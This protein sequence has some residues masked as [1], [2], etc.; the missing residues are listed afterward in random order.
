MLRPTLLAVSL[1]LFG[2]MNAAGVGQPAT[3]RSRIG[4][5]AISPDGNLVAMDLQ[6][7]STS[8]IYTVS[9]VTGEA[10]R[11][12]KA[13]NGRET[14]PA[15]SPDGKKIAYTYWPGSGARSRIM[16]INVDGSDR[17][18]WPPSDVA[19]V[20]PV[21][22]PDGKTIVFSRFEYYGSY[23]PIAQPRP[24]EWD[25]YAS[26]LDGK[27]VRQ[28]TDERFYMV[29]APS[30]SPDGQEM[31]VVAEGIETKQRIAI[32]SITKPGPVL[33]SIQPN[34]PQG[35]V[36]LGPIFAYPNY[37]P[38]GSILFMAANKRID[39]DVYRLNPDTSAIEKLTN[40]NGYATELRVSAD[41]NTAVFLKWRKNWM[42]EVTDPE[43]YLLDVKTR[44][45]RRLMIH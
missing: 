1:A 39:Y 13:K 26:D 24:Y 35:L 28:L 10:V 7:G 20:S 33:R 44:A 22:S 41:G 5:V 32:Y 30:V 16:I 36:Y 27:N 34:I 40:K 14:S 15:F 9:V 42:S 19:D 29:S 38:D 12:T 18:E 11:L 17:Y 45:T 43:P 21:F 4:S 2:L 25:F 3:K 8:F 37:L 23:S 6:N 31:V